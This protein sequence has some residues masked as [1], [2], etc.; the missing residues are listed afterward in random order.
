MGN[1]PLFILR[2]VEPARSGAMMPKINEP[3][4]SAVKN[5]RSNFLEP[6]VM[7]TDHD[8]APTHQT[9]GKQRKEAGHGNGR[10]DRPSVAQQRQRHER[11][12][13][14]IELT[15]Q[16]RGKRVSPDQHRHP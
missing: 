1:S 8:T 6:P 10:L 14:F 9:D 11:D 4:M 13:E 16:H 15:R 3:T 2:I 5:D 7:P 12:Q